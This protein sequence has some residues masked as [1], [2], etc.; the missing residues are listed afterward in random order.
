MVNYVAST[1][2]D[3]LMYTLLGQLISAKEYV[4]PSVPV[5]MIGSYDVK[6]PEHE[7]AIS[8]H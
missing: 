4:F 2:L 5:K 3:I 1:T 6:Q 8:T 7:D